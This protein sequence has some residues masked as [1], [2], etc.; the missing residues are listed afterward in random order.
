MKAVRYFETSVSFYLTTRRRVPEIVV[1]IVT[2]VSTS[3][4]T[5][6]EVFQDRILRQE[7]EK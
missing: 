5:E 7:G 3:R 2:A 4:P 6:I 1:F